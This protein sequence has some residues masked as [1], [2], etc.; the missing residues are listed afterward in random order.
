MFFALVGTHVGAFLVGRDFSPIEALRHELPLEFAYFETRLAVLTTDPDKTLK[1]VDK[2]LLVFDEPALRHAPDVERVQM[3]K[4]F[5]LA[6]RARSLRALKRYAESERAAIAASEACVL[7][8]RK[9]CDA[10]RL[11][12][13]SRKLLAA[14][15]D[16]QP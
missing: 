4:A 1:Y 12:S 10:Q 16:E 3:E 7:A 11:I 6:I 5:L 13:Y 2:S 8:R 14:E 15:W 9:S